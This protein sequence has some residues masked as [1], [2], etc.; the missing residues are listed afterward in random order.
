MAENRA[1]TLR[2][3]PPHTHLRLSPAA[4]ERRSRS[5]EA[6]LAAACHRP[7]ASS[8]INALRRTRLLMLLSRRHMMRLGKDFPLTARS[9]PRGSVCRSRRRRTPRRLH[10]ARALVSTWMVFAV[11][12]CS[13]RRRNR[14]RRLQH[15]AVQKKSSSDHS[16]IS[17]L[18]VAECCRCDGG[19]CLRLSL[20]SGWWSA[21]NTMLLLLLMLLLLHNSGGRT[22]RRLMRTSFRS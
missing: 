10:A 19:L 18:F 2:Y 7:P 4:C 12:I 5:T 15:A 21:R 1:P 20:T 8:K 17:R 16:R 11:S 13:T 6:A 3:L 14:A 22:S 9:Y